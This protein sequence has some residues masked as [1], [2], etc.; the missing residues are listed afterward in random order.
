MFQFKANHTFEQ[1]KG[2]ASRIRAK[3]PDRIP[4][5]VEKA[6]KS[7]IPDIDKHKFL[8]PSDLSVGQFVYVIR[9]RIKITPEKAIFVFVDNTLPPT[10]ELMSVLYKDKVDPD[11]FL[12][13][14]YAGESCFG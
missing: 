6:P 14:V 12:Y 10:A 7:D 13:A 11:G 5:I 8:V 9:K 2:E 1:R 4:V 3:Y